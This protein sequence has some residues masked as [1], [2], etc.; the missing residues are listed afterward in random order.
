M[1]NADHLLDLLKFSNV[2]L[3]LFHTETIDP[4]VPKARSQ[5]G[6]E[7]P[8]TVINTPI[9]IAASAIPAFVNPIIVFAFFGF[10]ADQADNCM[11][12]LLPEIPNIIKRAPISPKDIM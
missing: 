5:I 12:L 6:I 1:F 10:L 2:D 8:P 4:T 7:S 3:D 11:I 9:D